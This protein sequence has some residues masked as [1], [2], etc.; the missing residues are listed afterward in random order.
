MNH[1][2]QQPPKP[3]AGW[4]VL[5]PRGGP[6]GDG[7]AATLRHQGATPVVAP[8]INFAPTNDQATLDQA[9]ADLEA[10]AFDWLTVTSATT[11]DVLF[12]HRA[13]IPAA[14][15]GRRRRRDD[16][17]RAAGGR[18][19]RRPRARARQ[20]GG[21]DGRADDRPRAGGARHPHPPQ[22]DRQARA[23]PAPRRGGPP[24]AQ[25]RRLPDGRACRSP[26]ASPR[27][28]AT[29]ASTRSSSRAARSPS[30][31]TLQ[32]PE[33][34]AVDGHRRDRTAHREGRAAR[35]PP[36]RRRRGDPDRGRAHRSRRPLHASARCG[37][38]RALTAA[39]WRARRH[40][41][42]RRARRRRRRIAVLPRCAR[43][44]AAQ[45][46]CA[47]HPPTCSRSSSTRETTCGCRACACSPT[48]TRSS[49]RSPGVND[50]ERGWGRAGDSERVNQRAAG[51]GRRLAVVHPRRPRSRHAPGPHRL[52]AR[53][54]HADAGDRADVAALAAR[55]PAASDDRRARSTRSCGPATTGPSATAL[56]GVVDAAPRGARAG[57]LRQPRASTRRYPHRASLEAIAD[58]DVVLIAPSN[59][60]VS[61]GPILAV[62]GIREALRAT[63][64]R[65]RRSVADHRRPRRARHGRRLPRGD[66]RRDVGSRGRRALRR[67]LRRRTA[68]RV[69]AGRGGCRI[70]GRVARLGIRR[71]WS[72]LWMT[73][74]RVLG[75]ARRGRAVGGRA[76]TC[77]T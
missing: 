50:T 14:D 57:A 21:G 67:T 42:R 35:R 76:L 53:R 60:V 73:R 36:G 75:R 15:Q 74:S 6:W 69:A 1:A 2:P 68:G 26:I 47:R 5:V 25:R 29:A 70:R 72:P 12:A 17:G 18:L 71:S 24:R 49:T 66:R 45:S 9:L 30:R 23:H 59:P 48:S 54:P 22:R 62:P 27:T 7:V 56:P 13:T 8:L 3:L 65:R 39:P 51:V 64:S 37:R 61:I 34:P 77:P 41:A 43:G 40:A 19:P 33:I 38:I 28:S 44:P 11:V 20:L 32:F 58:A 31:C 4:R 55:R 46:G 10:G 52:A 16:R 63:P